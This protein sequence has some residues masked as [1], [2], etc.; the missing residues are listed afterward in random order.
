MQVFDA[1]VILMG[2]VTLSGTGKEY[3]Q[4]ISYSV[5]LSVWEEVKLQWHHLT[6]AGSGISSLV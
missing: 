4:I 2:L 6:L 5:V 1:V 3:K